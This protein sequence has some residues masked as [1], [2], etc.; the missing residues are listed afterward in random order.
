MSYEHI[1]YDVTDGVAA[2]TFNLPQFANAMDFQGVRETFD[3]LMRA[4]GDEDVGA[5]LITTNGFSGEFRVNWFVLL[6]FLCPAAYSVASIYIVKY[7]I[8]DADPML[9]AAGTLA[10]ASVF[11]LPLSIVSGQFHPLWDDPDLPE[12]F[13]LIHGTLAATAYTLFFRIVQLAGPVFYSQSTYLIAISGVT[14]GMLIFGEKHGVSFWVATAL[15]MAGLT[16]INIRQT[17]QFPGSSSS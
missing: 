10:T 1:L 5:V 14:W 13:I 15:I 12:L 16:I 7:P 2:I 6:G 17:H 11:L 3:A 8:H 9:L 4:E